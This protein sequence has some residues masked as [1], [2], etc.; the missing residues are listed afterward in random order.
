M[1]SSFA[2]MIVS[3]VSSCEIDCKGSDQVDP[4]A[5]EEVTWLNYKVCKTVSL[6]QW[7]KVVETQKAIIRQMR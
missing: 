3:C 7:Q 6:I 5:T 2:M 1:I 4:H